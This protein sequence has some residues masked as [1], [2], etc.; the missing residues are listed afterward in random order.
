ML[1]LGFLAAYKQETFRGSTESVKVFETHYATPWA[2]F[3]VAGVAAL[4]TFLVGAGKHY[5]AAITA[6]SVVAALIT[7]FQ[8]AG[9]DVGSA[10]NGTGG[11]LLLVFTI[12]GALVSILWLLIETEMIKTA[13]APEG[14]AAGL[15]AGG[16]HAAVQTPATPAA[17]YGDQGSST[18]GYA[19]STSSAAT[20][21][22]QQAPPYGDASASTYGSGA[23]PS[24]GDASASSYGSGAATYGQSGA[25]EGD[26]TTYTP[27]PDA[28]PSASGD[29]SE[30]TVFGASETPEEPKKDS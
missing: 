28:T 10:S 9:I 15:Q 22:G 19:Q 24:L 13:P 4:L 6:L 7:I 12:V 30:T 1:F 16:A 11:I 5:V 26:A 3:A 21:Y 20:S 17:G 27:L 23:A 14:Q 2:L 18:G 25:A 8:F 29:G